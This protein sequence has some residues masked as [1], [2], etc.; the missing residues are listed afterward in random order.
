[1]RLLV[2]GVVPHDKGVTVRDPHD[3][4]LIGRGIEAWRGGRFPTQRA[5][6]AHVTILPNLHPIDTRQVGRCVHQSHITL[7]NLQRVRHLGLASLILD[8][9]IEESLE[10][11]KVLNCLPE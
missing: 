3:D 1:M 9:V 7:L 8:A 2:T 6:A 11:L 10:N 4:W 5:I